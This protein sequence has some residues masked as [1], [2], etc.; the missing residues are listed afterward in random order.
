MLTLDEIEKPSVEYLPLQPVNLNESRAVNLTLTRLVRN[1]RLAI[2][3]AHDCV[4]A[5]DFGSW[6]EAARKAV[7]AVEMLAREEHEMARSE[8]LLSR[9]QVEQKMKQIKSEWEGYACFPVYLKAYQARHGDIPVDAMLSCI[10]PLSRARASAPSVP[11]K[12][13]HDSTPKQHGRFAPYSRSS[14]PSISDTA[15]AKRASTSSAL[16]P[17][18]FPH[19]AFL[20]H[21]RVPAEAATKSHRK[22]H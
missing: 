6:L 22:T 19:P 1:I 18:A 8:E 17:P 13:R 3:T 15:R 21:K 4:T 5:K 9:E 20:K 10:Q 16:G 12:S 2:N 7:D 14:V 11:S